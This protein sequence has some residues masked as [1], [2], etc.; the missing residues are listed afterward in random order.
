MALREFDRVRE[1]VEIRIEQR[2]LVQ[3]AVAAVIVTAGT[4]YG[5][6]TLGR[7][8]TPAPVDAPLAFAVTANDKLPDGVTP[9]KGSEILTP[10]PVPVPPRE[11]MADKVLAALGSPSAPAFTSDPAL[12]QVAHAEPKDTAPNQAES[13]HADAKAVAP[14]AAATGGGAKPAQAAPPSEPK[15]AVKA[16]EARLKVDPKHKPAVPPAKPAPGVKA[17]G[18]ASAQQP[19]ASHYTLQLKAFKD[20]KEAETYI[21][22]LKARGHSPSIAASDVPGKGTFYRVRLGRFDDLPAAQSY[23][24]DFESKEGYPT[25]ILAQ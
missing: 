25:M 12:A 3:A 1:R 9:R 14:T 10:M 13:T 19:R 2:Q 17:G 18:P 6:Y 11:V 20:Q 22:K 5:G 4:F 16:P 24:K 23:Q 8:A 7:R 21:E 15:L